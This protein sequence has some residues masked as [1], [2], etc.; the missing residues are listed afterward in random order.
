MQKPTSI[1]LKKLRL[2]DNN[3]IA[4]QFTPCPIVEQYIKNYTDSHWSA[5]EQKY[6]VYYNRTALNKLFDYLRLQ[7]F[8]VDYS[9]LKPKATA[10]K[11]TPLAV[12]KAPP[13][14]ALSETQLLKLEGYKKWLYQKRFSDNTV[15]TYCEVTAFFLRYLSLK[16]ITTITTRSVEQFNYDFIV[17]PNKSISYQNQCITGIKHYVSFIHGTV[18]IIDIERPSK[19]KKLP[20]ILSKHEVK[21]LFE[22]TKNLKHKTL[23]SLVYSAG[24]RIGEALSLHLN[25]IDYGR[26]LI[27]IKAAKGK[28]DRYTLLSLNLI[29][30]L[31]T[32][33]KHYDPQHYLFEG[34]GG[35]PYSQVSARQV[36]KQS[37]AKTEIKKYTTLHTLRHSF[38]THLLE[39]GVDLRYI[40]ELLGHNSPK[41]TMI[42]THVSSTNLIEIKNP[43]DYL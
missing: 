4:L 9:D 42:Y 2:D 11:P 27:H 18:D 19:D 10:I 39:S 28:K 43:F 24:L 1:T 32:Y 40:Q 29:P 33:I 5:L 14:P 15:N 36:L 7:H 8:F 23:L 6:Y 22:V 41:T 31:H 25:D 3:C 26:G 38:A 37:V 21:T 16:H 35:T 12:K 34:R 20:N 30:L 13:L 17:A